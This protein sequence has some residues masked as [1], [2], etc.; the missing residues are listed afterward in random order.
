MINNVRPA[1]EIFFRATRIHIMDRH[2]CVMINNE[3][4]IRAPSIT[5]D[6]NDPDANNGLITSIWGPPTWD[7]FHAITFGYPISPTN[8]QKSDYLNYF[9]FLGKVLP[10]VF[11][12]TSYQKFIKEGDTLLDINTMNSRESLTRW[13]FALHNA[14]NKKLGV[15]Y[16]ETYE[17]MCY[18]YNSFRAKCVK[19]SNGCKTPLDIKAKSYQKAAIQRAPLLNVKYAK[20]FSNYAKSI[21]LHS[22]DKFVDYH[23]TIKRNTP[24]W[25][26]RDCDARRIIKYMRKHGVSSIDKNT[27]YGEMPS[28]YELVLMSMLSTTIDMPKLDELYTKMRANSVGVNR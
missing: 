19:T 7:S 2:R 3:E 28:K 20:A 27:E 25:S 22:Y 15:D 12:R 9:T 5:N 8:E 26:Q 13:G 10:C 11:C 6:P 1:Y 14:V 16:G 24:E 17:E 21:G 23:A 4:L 18:K